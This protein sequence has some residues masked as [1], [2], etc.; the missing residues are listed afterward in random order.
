MTPASSINQGLW[1]K[2]YQ[3][4]AHHASERGQLCPGDGEQS[5]KFSWR[6]ATCG[7]DLVTGQI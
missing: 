1:W 3:P 2:V 5:G 4:Q 7:A 6:K